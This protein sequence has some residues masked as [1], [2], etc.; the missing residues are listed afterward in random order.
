MRLEP[1]HAG[2]GS[3]PDGQALWQSENDAIGAEHSGLDI[4]GKYSECSFRYFSAAVQ[5][6]KEQQRY[7]ER[8][9]KQRC[10]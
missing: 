6:I 3:V 10:G 4:A 2:G 7:E 9:R 1:A 5:R 8:I